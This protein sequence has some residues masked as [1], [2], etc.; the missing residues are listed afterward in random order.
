MG[1]GGSALARGRKQLATEQLTTERARL[2]YERILLLQAQV[3]VS[4]VQGNSSA[5]TAQQLQLGGD[6]G[7]G[8]AKAPFNFSHGGQLPLPMPAPAP[9]GATA[10]T[11]AAM[12]ALVNRVEQDAATHRAELAALHTA[13]AGLQKQLSTATLHGDAP[14]LQPEAPQ[15]DVAAALV[16]SPQPAPGGKYHA[17]IV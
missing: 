13:I 6:E 5:A 11:E 1:C 12:E 14:R 2:Q 7:G 4:S 8:A 9:A 15:P 10:R 17:Y 3:A 16:P